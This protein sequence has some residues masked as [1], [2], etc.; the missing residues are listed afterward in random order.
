MNMKEHIL[1]ALRE[2]FNRWEEVLGGMSQ[3]QINRRQPPEAWSIKDEMAHLM[4]WQQRSVARLEAALDGG[5]PDFPR[6]LDG[7]D[8]DSEENLELVNGWI[9]ETHR[10]QPWTVVVS[11]WRTVFLRLLEL[12]E[13]IPE[14]NLLDGSRYPW[15]NGSP[16]VCVLLATYDHHQEHLDKLLARLDLDGK[17]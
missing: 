6:W 8:A 9:H 14:I 12:G 3:E 11:M 13:T 16:V 1:A 10:D 4:A 17:S 2:Q 5:E 15:M 7:G